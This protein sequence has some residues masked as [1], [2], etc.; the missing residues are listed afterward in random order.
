MCAAPESLAV[1]GVRRA[2]PPA[3]AGLDAEPVT[4]VLLDMLW[5]HG[6]GAP[7]FRGL[8]YTI[9]VPR[10]P[11]RGRGRAGAE[12]GLVRMIRVYRLRC[13][14]P[15]CLS[16]PCVR[17]LSAVCNT[18]IAN[19]VTSAFGSAPVKAVLSRRERSDFCL[20][21]AHPSRRILSD[22]A[23]GVISALGLPLPP[24]NSSI[25]VSYPGPCIRSDL[26][27]AAAH[28]FS[29]CQRSYAPQPCPSCSDVVRL[30]YKPP[31]R[32]AGGANSGRFRRHPGPC[33]RSD[34][35][36]TAAHPISA[37]QRSQAPQPCLSCSDVVHLDG[38]PP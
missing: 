15:V 24:G 36:P 3:G 9:G 21:A 10:S 4:A 22:A 6:V 31:V 37:S 29:A 8:L 26:C 14:C 32:T 19:G 11:T 38:I 16:C 7:P 33:I 25:M 28:P 20:L 23:N 34:L 1:G 13:R 18:S 12:A 5:R 2:L 35:C 27:L 17:C 30:G